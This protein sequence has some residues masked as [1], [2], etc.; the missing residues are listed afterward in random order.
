MVII[1]EAIDK[2]KEVKDQAVCIILDSIKGSGV[3]YFEQMDA[4]HSVKFNNDEIIK[5][6]SK[7]KGI[8]SVYGG[9]GSAVAEVMAE[10]FGLIA[11][12]IKEAISL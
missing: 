3:S 10:K 4:N 2:V 5:E 9:L 6:F 8:H 11:D 7:M 1:D 12:Q